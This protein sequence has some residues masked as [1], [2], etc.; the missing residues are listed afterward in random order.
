VAIQMAESR[1][2]VEIKIGFQRTLGQRMICKDASHANNRF[3]F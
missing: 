3:G 1:I 2:S